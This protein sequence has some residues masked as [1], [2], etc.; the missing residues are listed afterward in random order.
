MA[1]SPLVPWNSCSAYMT[2]ALGVS[3]FLYFPHCL[4]NLLNP[5]LGATFAFTGR[6]LVPISPAS[7]GAA[8]AK[9]RA[10]PPAPLVK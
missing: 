3:T 1:T 2:A 9:V 6:G 10:A 7:A 8:S 4:L 5:I